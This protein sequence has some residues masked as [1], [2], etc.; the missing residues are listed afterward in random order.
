MTRR[1]AAA[2]AFVAA[3]SAALI[4]CG[5]DAGAPADV[6]AATSRSVP[7]GAVLIASPKVGGE[8]W[9]LY[10]RERDDGLCL[11]TSSYGLSSCHESRRPS[12]LFVV[13]R[14]ANTWCEPEAIVYGMASRR[15]DRVVVRATNGTSSDALLIPP[16]DELD[17]RGQIVFAS[18][19]DDAATVAEVEAQAQ[20]GT[21]L[22]TQNGSAPEVECRSDGSTEVSQP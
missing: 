9:R 18:L 16:P 4:G 15:V 21:I 10:G 11:Y 2:V 13:I 8:R 3:M 5:N 14:D 19:D 7:N 6:T 1:S 12:P 22:A 17:V 20:D